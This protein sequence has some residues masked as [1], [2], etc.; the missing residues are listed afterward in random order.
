MGEVPQNT[1]FPRINGV[2]TGKG[3]D[4]TGGKAEGYRQVLSMFRKD[5]EERLQRLRFFLFEGLGS[6]TGKF[7]E[8]HLTS[9]IT[10]IYALKSASAAIGAA[11]IS[12]EAARLEEAGK[13]RDLVFIQENLPAF[14][15]H[16]AE[17]VKN[18]RAAVEPPQNENA[19]KT[20]GGN[21]F[22]NL[23][24]GKKPAGPGL[25]KGSLSEH[26]PALEELAGALKLQYLS[27]IDGILD[28]LGKLPLDSK[29]K[30]ILDNISDQ[31]LMAEFDGAI[32]TV[33]ELIKAD[34]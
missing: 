16:L 4:A 21:F 6:A 32:K 28:E 14:T 9:L 23:F 17:L 1:S 20:G 12:S 13:N 15:E 34:K 24:A 3:L 5:S 11:E 25:E 18:I 19:A 26:I 7:P 8:K 27:K 2:D 10:Q 22:K 29:N 31:V 30:K 33:Q